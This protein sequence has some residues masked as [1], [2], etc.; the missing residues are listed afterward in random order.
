MD[1]VIKVGKVQGIVTPQVLQTGN[2]IHMP[3]SDAD[4]ALGELAV[5]IAEDRFYKLTGML[6]SAPARVAL[7]RLMDEDISGKQLS[8]IWKGQLTFSGE[9]FSVQIERWVPWVTG[10]VWALTVFVFV[11]AMVLIDKHQ[12]I[13]TIMGCVLSVLFTLAGALFATAKILIPYLLAKKVASMVERINPEL[14]EL[15]GRW[16]DGRRDTRG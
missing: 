4:N 10:V 3:A 14:P 1:R 16:R 9:I 15:L 7:L 6:T 2:V 11:G 12:P 5:P 8:I 13:S